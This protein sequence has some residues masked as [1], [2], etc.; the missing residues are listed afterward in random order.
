MSAETVYESELD[1]PLKARGKVRDIY[2]T[3]EGILLVA[4]DRLSAFDVVFPDPI[5]KKGQILN[6]LAAYWFSQTG[7]IVKNHVITTD[8][9]E[10]SAVAG[11]PAMAGRCTLCRMAKPFPVEC[12]VRGYLEGSAW[13]DY[14]ESGEVSG[15]AL[16]AGL[17]RRG[18]LE[19][20]LFTPSTKAEEGHDEPISFERV[21]ELVGADAAEKLRDISIKLFNFAHDK[22]LPMGIVLSDTKFEFGTTEDGEIILIDE[23]LTPDSSRFWEAESYKP[24]GDARSFDKQYVRDYVESIGWDKKPPAPQLPQEVIDGMTKRYVDIYGLITGEAL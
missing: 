19:I 10:I 24:E 16:P 11:D 7:H 23:A 14:L 6:Q 12:V 8:S 21:V 5:P 22:L 17:K 4:S 18:K 9:S 15:I 20:P 2:E 3:P 1:L 13:K